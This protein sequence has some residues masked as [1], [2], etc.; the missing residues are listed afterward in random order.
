[1]IYKSILSN[2]DVHYLQDVN[3]QINHVNL[4]DKARKRIE[5]LFS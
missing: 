3:Q 4:I 2:H 5:T 1:M